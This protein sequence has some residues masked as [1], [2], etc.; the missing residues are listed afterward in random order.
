[1]GELK[2]RK[3]ILGVTGGIAAYKSV[4]LARLLIKAGA[5]V[6]VVMTAAARQFV[7]ALSF[8]A[9]TGRQVRGELF[10]PAHE[11]A[12]GHIELARWA[13]TLL[14]A[15]A[16]ADFI[17]RLAHGLAD[18]LLSTLCLASP[19]RLLLA[20]AM[21][22]QM[23]RNPATVANIT[24]LESPGSGVLGPAEGEQAC[25]DIGPG[26]MLEPENV[27]KF[28]VGVENARDYKGIRVLI[29]AGPTREA[30]DPVRFIGNRS[31]GKMGYAIADAF[32]RQ[33][34]EVSLVSGPVSLSTPQGVTRINVESAEEMLAA[35]TANV[36]QADI[37]VACAAVADYRPKQMAPG[38]IKKQQQT[39]QLEL[40]RNPDILAWVAGQDNGP[41]TVGFAAETSDLAENAM[42]KR[43]SKGVDMIAANQVGSGLGFDSADNAL[44]VF[45]EHGEQQ[46]PVQPKTILAE[47]SGG[48]D[49]GALRQVDSMIRRD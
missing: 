20:P 4:E 9:V 19:A 3:I 1:M 35:V 7:G 48:S 41:Y 17:A 22:Q 26:R 36:A 18:D 6:Q 42:R 21:N 28:V 43:R 14:I 11:A 15:P 30:L 45:W 25:G 44:H 37:F 31:S 27:I 5:E 40:V 10:D 29:T 13:D 38:K 46:F 2:G 34:A 12:M 33:G 24:T 39:M 23:W 32:A 49:K 8:Q 16:S 47:Q